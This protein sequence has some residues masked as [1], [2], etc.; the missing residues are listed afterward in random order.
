MCDENKLTELCCPSGSS[1]RPNIEKNLFEHR[2]S[3]RLKNMNRGK[4]T[5]KNIAHKSNTMPKCDLYRLTI[6]KGDRS[7]VFAETLLFLF[8]AFGFQM[9]IKSFFSLLFFFF[10]LKTFF[11]SRVH[12]ASAKRRRI[13]AICTSQ[14]LIWYVYYVLNSERAIREQKKSQTTIQKRGEN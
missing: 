14:K 9:N 4:A 13:N 8:F 10:I 11:L 7:I 5:K 1:S 2:N 6:Q 12:F 3:A